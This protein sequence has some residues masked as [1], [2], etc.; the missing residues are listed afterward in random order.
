MSYGKQYWDVQAVR[1]C[2]ANLGCDTCALITFYCSFLFSP[3]SCRGNVCIGSQS[4]RPA[5]CS[6]FSAKPFLP[7]RLWG[8]D[9]IHREGLCVCCRIC[10][11]QL[12]VNFDFLALPNK[13]W[14]ARRARKRLELIVPV[15][16]VIV[17]SS[18]ASFKFKLFCCFLPLL[19]SKFVHHFHRRN[20]L[21]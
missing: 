19:L 16:I 7:R 9:E 14:C 13:A 5:F 11:R 2:Q 1:P 18:L 15:T 20:I 10:F 8:A 4:L 12:C 3:S 21:R 6:S 17:T